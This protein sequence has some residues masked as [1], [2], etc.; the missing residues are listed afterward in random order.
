MDWVNQRQMNGWRAL[1]LPHCHSLVELR[2]VQQNGSCLVA[3]E[4]LQSDLSAAVVDITLAS[5]QPAVSEVLIAICVLCYICLCCFHAFVRGQKRSICIL[6]AVV[7]PLIIWHQ[8]DHQWHSLL[9]IGQTP[10]H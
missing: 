6:L 2:Y 4:C 1:T 10:T 3:V 8:D 9:S 5:S 7:G